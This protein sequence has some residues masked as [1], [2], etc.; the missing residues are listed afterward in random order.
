M[1]LADFGYSVLKVPMVFFFPNINNNYLDFQ[2]FYF[3][4]TW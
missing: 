3:E 4:C 1:I 2:Y